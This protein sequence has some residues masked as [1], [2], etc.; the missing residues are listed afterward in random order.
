MKDD[1]FSADSG[2]RVDDLEVLAMPPLAPLAMPKQTLEAP[3]IAPVLARL[4]QAL[5]AR[6]LSTGR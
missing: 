2:D 4:A 1:V 3:V 6:R 5:G